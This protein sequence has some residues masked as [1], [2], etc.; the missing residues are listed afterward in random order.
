MK[1]LSRLWAQLTT[2]MTPIPMPPSEERME[3]AQFEAAAK[4]GGEAPLTID[5]R[6]RNGM[7][8]LPPLVSLGL[9][10]QIYGPEPVRPLALRALILAN[11][12]EDEARRLDA[13]FA[14]QT[15]ILTLASGSSSEQASAF[16]VATDLVRQAYA[17][18]KG[19]NI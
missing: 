11:D 15:D 10:N 3:R 6:F 1:V 12:M 13:A 9:N 14:D 7:A 17:R 8:P 4:V 5:F 16:Y 19:F 2:L 18:I